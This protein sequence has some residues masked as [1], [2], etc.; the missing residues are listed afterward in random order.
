MAVSDTKF[1]KELCLKGENKA[2]G[3]TGYIQCSHPLC[4]HKWSSCHS[5]SDET[6]LSWEAAIPVMGLILTHI[7]VAASFPFGMLWGLPSLLLLQIGGSDPK[8]SDDSCRDDLK[9][10]CLLS[11]CHL[12]AWGWRAWSVCFSAAATHC[13]AWPLLKPLLIL[14]YINILDVN[15]IT[16][17]WTSCPCSSLTF[18]EEV[19]V[20]KWG[21]NLCDF[22]KLQN[23]SPNK[24]FLS[25]FVI[26]EK[27][28]TKIGVDVSEVLWPIL[29]SSVLL[30]AHTINP[31]PV[32]RS[33]TTYKRVS[34]LSHRQLWA[35]I[36]VSSWFFWICIQIWGEFCN[37]GEIHAALAPL[38][39]IPK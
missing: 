35:I 9:G 23:H 20:C 26:K 25:E 39:A 33:V 6:L 31:F 38:L 30:Y 17:K 16:D 28:K 1:R 18:V 37:R 24:P 21:S 34:F 13:L 22:N 10:A 3:T 27:S 8:I 14:A 12:S 32:K 2:T 5:T 7:K 11:L 15:V 4:L 19:M 36:V 29:L